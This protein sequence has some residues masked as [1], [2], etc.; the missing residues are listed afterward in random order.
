LLVD[1][2]RVKIRQLATQ[3]LEMIAWGDTQISIC[4]GI[5]DHL[6]L[7]EHPAFEVRRDIT[8]VNVIHKERP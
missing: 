8:R 4:G 3:L 7:A 1:A 5:V 2:D 6:E